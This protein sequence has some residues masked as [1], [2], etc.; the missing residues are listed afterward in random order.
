[1]RSGA[2]RPD[3]GVGPGRAAHRRDVEFELG[4]FLASHTRW[5]RGRPAAATRRRPGPW[6]ER[7]S[8]GGTPPD[9]IRDCSPRSGAARRRVSDLQRLLDRLVAAGAPGAAGWVQNERG[10]RGAASG[11]AT[12]RT[13]QPMRP[14]LHFRAGSLTKSLVAAAVLRL[15]AD[16]PLA[17]AAP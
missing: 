12:R 2:L 7:R 6:L 3:T 5:R 17:L 4:R 10:S 9:A 1:S 8:R 11:L 14:G 16:G 15:A 13:R